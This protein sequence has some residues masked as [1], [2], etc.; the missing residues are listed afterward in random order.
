LLI[1]TF[2]L[3]VRRGRTWLA[4]CAL[5]VAWA[6][7]AGASTVL[8]LNDTQLADIAEVVVTGRVSDMR[9]LR[10]S[11]ESNIY[12]Y[13]TVS[14]DE[15]LKGG[16][17]DSEL[18]V[19][20]PG[21]RFGGKT[22]WISGSPE[23]KRGEQVLL[24]LIRVGDGSLRTVG[25][26]QGK[27]TLGWDAAGRRLVRRSLDHAGTRLVPAPLGHLQEQR[28]FRPLRALVLARAAAAA[29]LRGKVD[30]HPRELHDY[31]A[32]TQTV[33]NFALLGEHWDASRIPVPFNLASNSQPGVAGGGV[34]GVEAGM[35]AWSNAG[36][37][38]SMYIG[39]S[40]APRRFNI[41]DGRNTVTFDDPFAEIPP[42]GTLAIGGYCSDGNLITEADLTFNNG[43]LVD[44]YFAL[45]NC[46]EET[47]AHELGHAIGIDHS[48]DP[49]ALMYPFANDFCLGAVLRPDDV[50][51]IMALYPPG[52]SGGGGS[53]PP[54]GGLSTPTG[55]NASAS[56]SVLTIGWNTVA[57]ASSYDVVA[58]GVCDPCATVPGPP[59]VAADVPAG[60]YQIAVRARSGSA[61]S[62]LSSTVSVTVGGGGGGGALT[63]P[64]GV[65]ASASGSVLT[66]DWNTVGG[67]SSYDVVALGVCDPCANVPGPPVVA[68]VPAGSYQLGVRA[69]SGSAT[70][71]L[72][73]IATVTVG[74][75]G[76]SGSLAAPTGLSASASGDTVTIRFNPVPGASTYEVVAVGVCDPCAVVG[77][78]EVVASGVPPG[79]YT[80]GVRARSGADA[81][82]LS[83]TVPLVV[84]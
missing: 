8:R 74:G 5:A 34:P 64:T 18:T 62:A 17:T 7:P 35:A 66:L 20:Q 61:A 81:G 71:A 55:V 84:N 56:G 77:T 24:F 9:T 47:A 37:A 15:V 2:K 40:S 49:T 39:G 36:A 29:P 16:V 68:E 50:A 21:G 52:G 10:T 31:A 41:C 45:P 42:D 19:K 1:S 22:A 59:L 4:A 69:R 82:P 76:G 44:N 78:T 33:E 70:S 67:A 28:E 79:S 58:L 26:F 53:T 23:F 51:A 38:F 14:I 63:A 48:S 75:G 30:L 43:V 11:P 27:F 46:F 73:S 57:G 25:L 6:A 65:N 80:I 60:T 32:L 13:V 12:T 54:P 3:L 72:S 83:N